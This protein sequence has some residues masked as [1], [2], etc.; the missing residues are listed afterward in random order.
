MKPLITK[1]IVIIVAAGIIAP[2]A[3]FA[4]EYYN[5]SN[6]PTSVQPFEYIPGNST[7][8]STVNY[9]GTEY[10]IFLD[11]NSTG[12]VADISQSSII[13]SNINSNTGGN[14]SSQNT[15]D[16]KSGS[17]LTSF[18]YDHVTVYEIKN[19]SISALIGKII[20]GN[21]SVNT[22]NKTVNIFAYD[23][24]ST[25]IVF[26]QENAINYSI[27]IHSTSRDAVKYKTYFDQSANVSLFYSGHNTLPT[28]NYITLNSTTNRTYINIM[29][30]NRT[31]LNRD[32]N[33]IQKLLVNK[34]LN[35]STANLY[36]I[37][38]SGNM[39][40]VKLY[41]GIENITEL[42]KILNTTSV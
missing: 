26:G 21:N 27:D 6:V 17:T 8:I 16:K 34:E 23:A 22:L 33:V 31:D 1:I 24:S 13:N 35:N 4:Y 41:S 9:N 19:V 30:D 37:T 28:V 38:V 29:P 5:K 18:T 42:F 2:A 25:F 7:V 36:N 14:H 40:H 15:G 11:D 12:I 3:Y 20:K 32:K 10:Y 39:I